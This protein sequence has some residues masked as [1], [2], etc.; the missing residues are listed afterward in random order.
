MAPIR[1][2]VVDDSAVARRLVSEA[3]CT[4][5]AIEVAGTA[6]N[7]RLALQKLQQFKPQV[8]AVTLDVEMPE[9]DGIATLIEIRKYWPHLPVIMFSAIT[10]RGAAATL[11]A[12]ARGANDYVCKPTS[13]ESLGE[14]RRRVADDLCPRVKAFAAAQT[15][16]LQPPPP[17]PPAPVQPAPAAVHSASPA[18]IT[19]LRPP[20]PAWHAPVPPPHMAPA[21][22]A[23]LRT[24]AGRS[25]RPEVLLIGVSTGGPNAL[26]ELIPA[27]PAD[28]PLPVLVTQH[29]P[30]VFTRLLA[31]RLDAVSQLEVRECQGDERLKAG[32]VYIA[33][34]DYHMKV[35]G[36]RTD[37]RLYLDQAPPENSCR[38][39][40]DAM[41]RS[42]VELWGGAAIAVIL[43]GM[44]QDGLKGCQLLRDA[45]GQVV[46]QDQATSVIWGMPGAIVRAGIADRILPL[47]KIATEL[48]TLTAAISGAPARRI[49]P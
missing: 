48:V 36:S 27:L 37:P 47:K 6:S 25:S 11:D 19:P 4:D 46:A 28:F 17:E 41:F 5:P 39:A 20:T 33:K 18:P 10:E 31:D 16:R 40:V 13:A 9:L 44:G 35:K 24:S 43:T 30:P 7:G 26:A 8:D 15:A 29:M 32:Y 23:R 45:G 14:A 38:P 12:I 42:A 3:L 49:N 21:P 22:I 34:G 1:V 2:L